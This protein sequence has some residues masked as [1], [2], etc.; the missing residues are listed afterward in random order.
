LSFDKKPDRVKPENRFPHRLKNISVFIKLIQIEIYTQF[1]KELLAQVF[2][3]RQKTIVKTIV[4]RLLNDC[5]TIVQ[6]L[7]NYCI[8]IV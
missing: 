6:P 3:D 7:C 2:K 5:I 8:T 4:K 1:P